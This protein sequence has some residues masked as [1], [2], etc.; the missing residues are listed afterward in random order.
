MCKLDYRM[1]DYNRIINEMI[2]DS[3]LFSSEKKSIVI[4]FY[5]HL[6]DIEL[7]KKNDSKIFKFFKDEIDSDNE[8]DYPEIESNNDLYH[9]LFHEKLNFKIL[10]IIKFYELFKEASDDM[11]D[12]DDEIRILKNKKRKIE[13]GKNDSIE[14]GLNYKIHE[15]DYYIRKNED[16]KNEIVEFLKENIKWWAFKESINRPFKGVLNK[17]FSSPYQYS[18]RGLFNS[19]KS[20]KIDE[21]SIYYNKFLFMPISDYKKTIMTILEDENSFIELSRSYVRDNNILEKFENIFDNNYILD[22]RKKILSKIIEYYKANEYVALVN[23]I[24]MQVEGIFHDYCL[25]IEIPEK[26]LMNCSMYD[27]LQYLYKGKHIDTF[28]NY[29]AHHFQAIRNDVAHGYIYKEIET[30]RIANL[31]FLDLVTVSFMA[32]NESI[33]INNSIK[34]IEECDG[35]DYESYLDWIDYYELK[36][37]DYKDIRQ[38]VE[39]MKK[40]YDDD[41]FW[42]YVKKMIGEYKIWEKPLKEIEKKVSILKR[43]GLR[44]SECIEILKTIGTK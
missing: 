23:I 39:G 35:S 19:I 16:E 33:P 15:I 24:P 14:R 32:N 1:S 31:L 18:K 43:N 42:E 25:A 34:I 2:V 26:K 5:S 28:Y 41:N 6:L 4:A 8:E 10:P 20:C 44:K 22:K 13:V 3:S 40:K 11:N 12:I 21:F 37:P 17:I 29:Y 30:E 9:I 27:K 38:K 7:L 36:H